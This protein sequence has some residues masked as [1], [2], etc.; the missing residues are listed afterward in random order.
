M[1]DHFVDH[2][3]IRFRCRLDGPEGAPWMVLSNSLVTDLTVWDQQVAAFGDR[4]RILRY[5][6]RGHGAT[7]V[8]PGP[9]NFE[10]LAEDAAAL[11]AHFGARDAVFAGV[12]MGA[13]TGFCLAQRHPGLV[14]RLVASDG[15]AATAPGGA[16][17]WAER[18]ALAEAQGMTGYADA[19]IP[20]WLSKRSRAEANPA[21]A[22][23]RAMIEAT[24]LAG[25]IACARALQGYDFRA[26]LA[27][28]R[29]PVLL[30]AGA[31][32]GAMPAT[33]KA[34]AEQIPDARFVEILDAGHIPGIERAPEFNAAL[35]RFLDGHA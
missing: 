24:P 7:S 19:T 2:D 21:V 5:D 17:G 28:M 23:L 14:A 30:I 10:Q 8:P 9:A 3:G 26:G 20:R 18:I 1:T 34:L 33:M 12:S 4:Y 27:T 25:M 13:A 15:Q 29:Q 11:M 32:D 31:E 35:A 16:Q 6:Q 22:L